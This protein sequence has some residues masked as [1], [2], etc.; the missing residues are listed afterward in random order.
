MDKYTATEQAY[1]NGYE[2]G[3]KDTIEKVLSKLKERVKTRYTLL[4]NYTSYGDIE[5]EI[6]NLAEELCINIKEFE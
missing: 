4:G 1:K 5:F 2:Q 3:C 6:D